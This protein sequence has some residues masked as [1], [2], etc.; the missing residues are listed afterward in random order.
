MSARPPVRRVGFAGGLRWLPRG[1]ELLFSGIGPMAGVGALWLLISMLTIVPVI[2][3]AIVALITP[4]LTAGVLAAYA[5][6]A[7]GRRP[8]P[9]TL[10]AAWHHPQRRSGLLLV[11]L[12]GIAGS[13]AAVGVLAAWLGTQL[14]AEQLESAM[15][16]PEALAATLTEISL[17][18]GVLASLV[19]ITLVLAAMYF[20]IPLIMFRRQPV[21]PSLMA[22]LRAVLVNWAAFLGMGLAVIGLA[23]GLGLIMLLVFAVLGLALGSAGEMIG[24]VLFLVMTL[25]VQMLM[26]GAQ[27]V[28][29]HDVFE[30]PVEAESEGERFLA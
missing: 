19:I 23:L 6:L 18:G 8:P 14:S 2:G 17:G 22:S 16:S 26:A 11:G 7:D 30:P 27:F 9:T 20:A 28:A 4:L 21:W 29:F 10:L 5:D 24:Q 15:A 25:L 3:Q 1:A 13:M 12:F